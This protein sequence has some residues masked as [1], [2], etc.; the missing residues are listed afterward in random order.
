[1]GLRS[2]FADLISLPSKRTR[3]LLQML[4]ENQKRQELLLRSDYLRKNLFESERNRDPKRLSSFEFS[5]FSQAGEDGVIEEIF[6]RVGLTN[7]FFVDIGVE[8][9]TE[10]NSLYLLHR[11][12]SGV[13]LEA[14]HERVLACHRNAQVFMRDRLNV[15]ESFVTAENIESLLSG[16]KCP[17]DLDFLSIDID[18]NDYHIWKALQTFKPR[19]LAIEYNAVFPPQVSWVQ[20]YVPSHVWDGTSYFGASL[21]ALEKLGSE[22]GYVLVGCSFVGSNA[23]FVRR[24]LVQGKF[25]TPATVENLYEPARYFLIGPKDGHPRRVGPF[26]AP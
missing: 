22:K 6:K 1:M 4:L 25:V 15:V 10:N 24:D 3:I 11:G 14:S 7:R 12:W 8:D 23:F 26:S 18:G 13:W 16:A 2:W 19:V 17:R 9:G 20:D 5:V 21:S